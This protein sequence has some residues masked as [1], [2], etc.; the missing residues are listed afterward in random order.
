[1]RQR[2]TRSTFESG[3]HPLLPVALAESLILFVKSPP[4]YRRILA[5]QL[6]RIYFSGLNIGLGAI[7]NYLRRAGVKR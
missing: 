7:R 5:T 2:N 6:A 3:S 4:T 1:M